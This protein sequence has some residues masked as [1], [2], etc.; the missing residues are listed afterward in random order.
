MGGKT[1]SRIGYGAMGLSQ[2]YGAA[3][4]DE[5]KDVLRKAVEIGCTLWDTAD[6]YGKGHNE[7]L[8]SEVLK[9]PGVRE[10]V[11]LVT[12]FGFSLEDMSF[13]GGDMNYLRSAIDKSI[14]R[15]GTT[16]DAWIIHRIPKE[17]PIEEV[18]TEMDKVRK[19]GKVKFIGIGECSADTLRRASK[20]TKIDFIESEYAPF[21][22]DLEE[23]GVLELCKELDVKILAFS[24]LGK[25]FLTGRFRT[26]EDFK[27]DG[28]A[29]GNG[30]FPRLAKENFERN[31]KIGT[32]RRGCT[33]SCTDTGG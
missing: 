10:R 1:F 16:P 17:T 8:I 26:F 2:S 6:V 12:K 7:R 33:L 18:V 19:A 22:L 14:E 30:M 23:N 29:R 24:P 11:F 5:S 4:D 31:F 13:L 3:K 21:C 28:D 9:E 20:V 27:S 25:G 15:L 32:F